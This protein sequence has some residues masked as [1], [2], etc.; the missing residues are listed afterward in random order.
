M[1]VKTDFFKNNNKLRIEGNL[2]TLIKDIY[3]KS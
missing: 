3:Q 2:F 1:K